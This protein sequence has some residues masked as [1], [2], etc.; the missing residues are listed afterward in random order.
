MTAN[1]TLTVTDADY[2][3]TVTMSVTDVAVDASTTGGVQTLLAGVL[4]NAQLK[5]M[6]TVTNTTTALSAD[7]TAGSQLTW[8]FNSGNVSSVNNTFDFLAA[9]ETLVL[10]YTLT[11]TDSN[12][13]AGVDTRV[14]TI[15]IRGS[16]DAP[17]ITGT[18]AS[19]SLD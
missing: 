14:V 19:A 18:S 6:L 9:G 5:S 4:S 13:T 3:N 11:A 8:T 12:T 10:N 17:V 1:G 2:S 16:N 15:T 7:P